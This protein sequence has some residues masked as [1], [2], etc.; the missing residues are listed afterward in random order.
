MYRN[1]R[2]PI[3]KCGKCKLNLKTHCGLFDD[4]HDMWNRHRKCPGY[5][6]EE[7]Y[8]E[9]LRIQERTE[10]ERQ[11]KQS[12]FIR[13]EGAKLRHTEP[14]YDGRRPTKPRAKD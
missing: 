12:L 8:Q 7:H 4:P 13:R 9:Y 5:M 11:S 6:S 10:Q 14:H 1:G 2:R 3:R